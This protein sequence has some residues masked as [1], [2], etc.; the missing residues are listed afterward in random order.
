MKAEIHPEYV[1]SQVT[2]TCGNEFTTRSTQPEIRVEICSECHPFYT[3]KQK[4]VD[5]GGRIERFNKKRKQ[6]E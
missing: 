1:V 4:I 6:A 3:G 2:C 5:T